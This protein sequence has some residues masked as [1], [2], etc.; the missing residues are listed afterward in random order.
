ML[1]GSLLRVRTYRNRLMPQYLDVHSPDWLAAAERLLIVYRESKGRT[2]SEIEADLEEFIPDGPEQV[3]VKGLAKLLDD[4]CEYDAEGD[5]PPEKIR[6]SAFRLAAEYRKAAVTTGVAFDR[7]VILKEVA[8]ELTLTQD[9]VD[10]G[11]FAD[12]KAEQRVVSFDHCTAEYLLKRYNVALAQAVLIR[13]TGMEV[14]VRGESTAR[15][16]QLFRAAKFHKLIG[17]IRSGPNDSYL[18]QLDGP[19]SL[20]SS[21]QKYGLQLAL[22]LPTLMH[23]S[24]YE[25]KANVRWGAQRKERQFVLSSREGIASHTPDFGMFRPKELDV[26][27]E[28]F[29]KA[30]DE[31][32][33]SA[34]PSPV[35]LGDEIWVPDFHLTHRKTGKEMFIEVC[36]YWRKPSIE[37]QLQRLS[38]HLPNQYLLL[39]GEHFKTDDAEAPAEHRDIVR[40]KRTPSAAEVLKVIESRIA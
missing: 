18:I 32:T 17:S 1:T 40:Y 29:A 24:N 13:S 39:V 25:L 31:W 6:E 36:G 2:R 19:L 26:F 3:I 14:V 35:P 37:K 5:F 30:T 16:R 27:A 21:T 9:Q 15:F 7:N 8:D 4:R 10:I 12:L 34:D 20:F 28:N 38:T 22:F 33:L 23:C 11:L